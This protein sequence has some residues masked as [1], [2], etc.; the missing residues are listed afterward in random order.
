MHIA[1]LEAGR[2]NPDMPA[3]FR[4]YPDMFE[5]LFAHQSNSA[6]FRF[7]IIPVI[8]DVFPPTVDDFDGYLVTRSAYGVYDNAPFIPRLIVLIQKI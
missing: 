8:D 4:D 5:T 6:D 3:K 7:S 1:I 2:T